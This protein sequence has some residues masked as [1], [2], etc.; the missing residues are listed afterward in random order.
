MEFTWPKKNLK[1]GENLFFLWNKAEENQ[2]YLS[3]QAF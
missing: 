2:S 1:K 3:N